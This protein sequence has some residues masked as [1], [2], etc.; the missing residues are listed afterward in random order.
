MV[1]EIGV[2]VSVEGMIARILVQKRGVCEA[3]PAAGTCRPSDEGMEMEVLNPVNARPGQTVK[4]VMRPQAYLKGTIIVYALPAA[5]LIIGAI[6]GKNIGE[7]YLKDINSDI[8]AAGLGFTALIIT[9]II[10]KIWSSMVEKK[11]E[12]KPVIEEILES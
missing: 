7:A 9:F 2:V 4:V 10:I 11:E 3:C 8:I 5:A 1:E 6:I 12:Y